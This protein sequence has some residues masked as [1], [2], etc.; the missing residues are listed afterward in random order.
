[1]TYKKLLFDAAVI[2]EVQRLTAVHIR[3]DVA[4]A[5]AAAAAHRF[6]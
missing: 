1:M 3:S 6:S 2:T 4:A 5:A